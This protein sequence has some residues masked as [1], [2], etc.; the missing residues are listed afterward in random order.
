MGRFTMGTDDPDA[1]DDERP[2]RTVS[3]GSLAITHHPVSAAQWQR[4]VEA[5]DHR[6]IAESEG[7]SFGSL[8]V[9]VAQ[10]AVLCGILNEDAGADN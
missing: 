10:P 1:P 6:T 8:R 4:F 3:V 5:T 9:G 2:A 7:S